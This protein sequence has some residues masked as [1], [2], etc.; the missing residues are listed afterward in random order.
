MSNHSLQHGDEERLQARHGDVPPHR[1]GAAQAPR[2]HPHAVA[3]VLALSSAVD[4][5]VSSTVGTMWQPLR[6]LAVADVE[7]ACGATVSMALARRDA[8]QH[9]L[10]AGAFR[11]VSVGRGKLTKAQTV[12]AGS[13]VVPQ[14][15]QGAQPLPW[16][17]VRSV[18][19]VRSV[20]LGAPQCSSVLLSAL[21]LS[22]HPLFQ[23]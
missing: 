9:H 14:P 5:G 15:R 19:S 11:R 23:N 1:S 3:S 4:S 6:R 21:S 18:R 12:S 8:F 17:P 10:R 16:S 20:L 7:V 13:T 22:A 2:H